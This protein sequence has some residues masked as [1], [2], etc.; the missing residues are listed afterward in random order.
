MRP[1]RCLDHGVSGVILGLAF[2]RPRHIRL[3]QR[4]CIL[5]GSP[6]GF[7]ADG[8]GAGALGVARRIEADQIRAACSQPRKTDKLSPV[9]RVRGRTLF[10]LRAMTV[11]LVRVA[12]RE[13][14]KP[15]ARPSWHSQ[16]WSSRKQPPTEK[17]DMSE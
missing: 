13:V 11:F 5:E 6:R 4:P 2:V 1:S 8:R 12:R 3:V 10:M 14:T 9:T 17:V 7:R 15:S 16:A